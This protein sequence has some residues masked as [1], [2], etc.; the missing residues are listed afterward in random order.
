MLAAM[1]DHAWNAEPR[2]IAAA[3]PAAGRFPWLLS[4]FLVPGLG[5]LLLALFA[6]LYTVDR[7]LYTQALATWGAD[8]FRFPFVDTDSN[9]AAIDCARRG[10][11]V[12]AFNPCA[13]VIGRY[14]YSPLLLLAT[15][16]P[17][18][19]AW[20]V[21]IGLAIDLLFLAALAAL[22]APRRLA[23]QAVRI[24]ATLSPITAFAM[25]R[26]NFDVFLLALTVAAGLLVVR[27]GKTRLLAY[28]LLLLAAVI[29]YYP[30]MA[31]VVALRDRRKAIFGIAAACAAVLLAFVLTWHADILRSIAG[32]PRALY[33]VAAF[34]AVNL[35]R[36]L[37]ALMVALALS[38][39]REH[40]FGDVLFLILIAY[41]LF[42]AARWVRNPA[43]RDHILGLADT[44]L[45]LL[46]VG[47]AVLVPCFFASQSVYYRAIFILPALPGL[48]APSRNGR[49]NPAFGPVAL[50]A[51]FLL[52][53][54]CGR[55]G[56]M[57]ATDAATPAAAAV[58]RMASCGLWLARELVWWQFIALLGAVLWLFVQA[59]PLWPRG[60]PR[61]ATGPQVAKA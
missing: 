49:T 4:R 16:L 10:A 5:L 38:P 26:A 19:R 46:V 55:F 34:G 28:P 53:A 35:P 12:F 1:V 14:N 15:H 18:T 60:L 8:P 32:Q 23:E 11:D 13:A 52:W 50:M 47:A 31:L 7:P 54:E 30:V 37:P 58:W 17:V 45:A 44:D 25:E 51:P 36:G 21:P 24:A 41:A 2:L 33:Y 6:A 42:C 56:L 27:A 61:R 3:P 20:T 22:P 39:A 40:L 57:A 59:S 29:K 43:F 9:L 48:L